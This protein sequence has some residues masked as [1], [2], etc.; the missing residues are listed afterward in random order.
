VDRSSTAT[1]TNIVYIVYLLSQHNLQF[2][3][4]AFND[5]V[6]FCVKQSL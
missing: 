1:V 2:K 4:H 3:L 6:I 5:C